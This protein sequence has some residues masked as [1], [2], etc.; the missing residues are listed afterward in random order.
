MFTTLFR[1]CHWSIG[2]SIGELSPLMTPHNHLLDSFLMVGMQ[3]ADPSDFWP[4][5][6]PRQKM[7]ALWFGLLLL[8]TRWC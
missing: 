6:W 1:P 7:R 8:L 3:L 5:W 2:H 4:G